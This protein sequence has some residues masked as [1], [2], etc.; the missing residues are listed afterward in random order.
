[1]PARVVFEYAVIRIVPR[2]EREEFLN[3]GVIL[4]CRARRF[5]NAH[6]A[7][8][9]PRL[10]AFAPQLDLAT[11][12]EQL[13]YLPLI[14]Q[15]GASAGPIGILPLPERFRWLVAPR[16]TI[17]QPSPVHAGLCHDPQHE[18]ERLAAAMV[19]G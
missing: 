8:D 6:I 11:V 3:A 18:L 1:M 14:C 2:V 13:S 19:S 15:G 7:L 9:A 17:V 16:S 12:E 10:L 4:F 5:L